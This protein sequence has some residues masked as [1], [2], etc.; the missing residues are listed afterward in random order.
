MDSRYV[1]QKVHRVH[2]VAYKI[3]MKI[4]NKKRTTQNASLLHR[5]LTAWQKLTATCTG[6]VEQGA[7]VHEAVAALALEGA[8]ELPVRGGDE[9]CLGDTPIPLPCQ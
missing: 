3:N 2:Q 6:D 8:A 4:I 7:S 9:G 5:H 1:L